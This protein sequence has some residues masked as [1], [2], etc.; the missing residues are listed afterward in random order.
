[1][2]QN[3]VNHDRKYEHVIIIGGGDLIIAA[4]ILKN[5]PNVK[6][7][8]VCDIDERVIEVTKHFFSI[9]RT[10]E[11]EK[12]NGRL[13]IN[14]ESGLTYM[15]RLVEEGMSHKIGAVIVDCTDFSPEEDSVSA[16]LFTVDFYLAINELLEPHCGFA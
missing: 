14:V 9:G 11:Q 1:M 12:A 13:E 2:T 6:K 4:N 16:E 3:V 15:Q 7:V 10:I 5:Y 8:T